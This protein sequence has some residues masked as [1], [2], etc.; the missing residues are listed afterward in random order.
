MDP[1]VVR[2]RGWTG[3]WRTR[4]RSASSDLRRMEQATQPMALECAGNGR[5]FHKPAAAGLQWENGAVGRPCGAA[6]GWPTCSA[7][8]GPG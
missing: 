2:A 4:S 8:P 5:S 7:W 6:S 3:R 1:A